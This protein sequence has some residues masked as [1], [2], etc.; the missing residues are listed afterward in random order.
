MRYRVQ[1]LRWF[2]TTKS[3]A[4]VDDYIDAAD[5][6]PDGQGGVLFCNENGDTVMMIPGPAL[7]LIEAA[8]REFATPERLVTS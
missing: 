2:D 4:L 7:K 3:F 1:Y 6:T 5:C 8:D